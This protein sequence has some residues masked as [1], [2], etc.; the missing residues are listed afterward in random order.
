MPLT[1]MLFVPMG[2]HDECIV[3]RISS[4]ILID[5]IRQGTMTLCIPHLVDVANHLNGVLPEDRP[6]ATAPVPTMPN[7]SVGIRGA[8]L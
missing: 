8:P 3:C 7:P 1:E 2:Q 5:S 6:R 4:E